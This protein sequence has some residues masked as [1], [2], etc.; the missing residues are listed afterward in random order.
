VTDAYRTKQK[1]RNVFHIEDAIRSYGQFPTTFDGS[2]PSDGLGQPPRIIVGNTYCFGDPKN[3]GVVGTV[4]YASVNEV[5][6]SVIIAIVDQNGQSSLLRE[7]MSHAQLA[8]W[9]A[10]KDS[11]F[12]KVLP[13]GGKLNTAFDVFEWFVENFRHLSR[14]QLLARFAGAPDF[15]AVCRLSDEDLLYQFCECMVGAIPSIATPNSSPTNADP[16]TP[17]LRDTK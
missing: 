2:L 12:G 9:R 1:H 3:G 7:P 10:H 11:Y 8:D 16:T 5:E 13:V 4:T 17:P 15:E 14:D 6:S